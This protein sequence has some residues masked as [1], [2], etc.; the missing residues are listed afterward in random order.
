MNPK[1]RIMR[2]LRNHGI[3][4]QAEALAE[5]GIARLSARIFKLKTTGV[6]IHRDMIASKNRY[7]EPVSYVRYSLKGE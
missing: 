7:N 1:E 2:H 6:P 5:Y 4:T 3:I